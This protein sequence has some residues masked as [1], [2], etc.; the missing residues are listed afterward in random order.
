MSAERKMDA[1]LLSVRCLSLDILYALIYSLHVAHPTP[2]QT[3]DHLTVHVLTDD[4][5]NGR[6]GM[7]CM[8]FKRG[9]WVL[10][11]GM[12]LIIGINVI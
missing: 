7:R 6:P 11:Q 4:L 2:S 5:H 8:Q 3:A 9:V 1:F 12:I 10:D